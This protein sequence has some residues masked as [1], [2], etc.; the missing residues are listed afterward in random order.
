MKKWV[1]KLKVNQ[2]F[3]FNDVLNTNVYKF[4]SYKEIDGV[5]KIKVTYKLGTEKIEHTMSRSKMVIINN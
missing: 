2:L 1:I 3:Q 4:V 5:K